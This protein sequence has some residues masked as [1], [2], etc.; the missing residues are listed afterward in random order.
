MVPGAS[1]GGGAIATGVAGDHRKEKPRGFAG[2]SFTCSCASS[3]SSCVSCPCVSCQWPHLCWMRLDLVLRR[4]HYHRQHPLRHRRLHRHRLLHLH[5]RLR[6][7]PRLTPT[8]AQRTQ[9][10]QSLSFSCWLSSPDRGEH[11]PRRQGKF[12]A[13]PWALRFA[14]CRRGPAVGR[15]QVRRDREGRRG[16]LPF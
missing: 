1:T 2:F 13:R 5:R 11:N 7:A 15:G 12:L 10:Q 8:Q 3:S 4:D 16:K 9:P 6:L 14:D